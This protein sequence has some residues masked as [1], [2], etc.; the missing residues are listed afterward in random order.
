MFQKAERKQAKLRLALQG[1]SGSGKTFSALTIAR[2]VVGPEGKIA[3]IDTEEG[4]ASLYADKFDFD[5]AELRPLPAR[6]QP[7]NKDNFHPAN[8]VAM[9]KMAE[10]AGYDLIIIDSASHEWIGKGGVLEIHDAMPG[11]SW[12]NWAKC[13]PMHDEF[14]QAILRSKAHIIL[15][16]RSKAAHVQSEKDGKKV[17]EKLGLQ[18]QMRDGF[19]YELTSTLQMV[20]EMACRDKDRTGLFQ[21]D[22][23]FKPTIETGEML[24]DWM[25]KGVSPADQLQ[26]FL[27]KIEAIESE[28]GYVAFWNNNK[29]SIMSHPDFETRIKP[30]MSEKKAALTQAAQ[31]RQKEPA[32]DRQSRQP[33]DEYEPGGGGM[34]DPMPSDEAKDSSGSI[35]TNQM[36]AIQAYFS[37]KGTK[38]RESRLAELSNFFGAFIESTKA[39]TFEQASEFISTINQEAA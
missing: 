24:R 34:G 18:S 5:V 36:K 21:P 31:G 25:A 13:N 14:M 10:D 1:P 3:V 29:A 26:A 22:A 23:W 17:I 15:T 39:L 30:A 33:R 16:L 4:S 6:Q 12:T 7:G 27:N 19:E 38:D 20:G 9:I 37:K 8:F 2:G 35:T 32:Q 28:E 11:N